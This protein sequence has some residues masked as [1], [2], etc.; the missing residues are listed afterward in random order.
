MITHTKI[1]SRRVGRKSCLVTLD[2]VSGTGVA[3]E[4]QLAL[5]A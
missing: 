5:S 2:V 4:I 3:I 1:D